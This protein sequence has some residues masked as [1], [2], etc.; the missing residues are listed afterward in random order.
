MVSVAQAEL[1][2]NKSWDLWTQ[3]W[4]A[5]L[6]PVSQWDDW[7]HQMQTHAAEASATN[8]ILQPRQVDEM[9]DYLKKMDS[10][11]VEKYMNH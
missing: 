3:D 6:V 1:F 9:A 4:R 5:Q 11:M 7:V 2:N 10:K 8:G